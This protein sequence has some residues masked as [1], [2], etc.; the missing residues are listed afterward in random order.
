MLAGSVIAVAAAL[1]VAV[2]GQA[3]PTQTVTRSATTTTTTTIPTHTIYVGAQGFKFTP[4]QITNASV[5]D[6]LGKWEFSSVYG[7][8]TNKPSQSI[9]SILAATLLRALISATRAYRTRI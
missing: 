6:I 8:R 7:L 3:S 2:E 5:G 9:A 1:V 4:N